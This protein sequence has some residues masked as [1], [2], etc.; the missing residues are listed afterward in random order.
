MFS[1]S[2]VI[3][4]KKKCF[5]KGDIGFFS[6]KTLSDLS[7]W[8]ISVVV[9]SEG[10]KISVRRFIRGDLWFPTVGLRHSPLLW[11][12]LLSYLS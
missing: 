4:K 12:K 9:S 2:S 10:S 6:L 3:K 5:L 1:F 7:L 8:L 11:T